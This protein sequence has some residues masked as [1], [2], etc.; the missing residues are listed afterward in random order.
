MMKIYNYLEVSSEVQAL[1]RV[2]KNLSS[3]L[4]YVKIINSD[5]TTEQNSQINA[6]KYVFLWNVGS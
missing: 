1:K 5:V 4:L 3:P 2:V 6:K